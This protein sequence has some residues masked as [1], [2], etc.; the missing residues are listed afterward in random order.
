M[1]K[2]IEWYELGV[3]RYPNSPLINKMKFDLASAWYAIGESDRTGYTKALKGFQELRAR[4]KG[5]DHR[6]E[7][8]SAFGE[9]ETL[10]EVDRLEEAYALYSTINQDY[11]APNVIQVRMMRLKERMKKKRK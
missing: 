4:V 10:E 7:V 3:S 5:V 9:A 6:L 11:P 2:A 1:K 8:E